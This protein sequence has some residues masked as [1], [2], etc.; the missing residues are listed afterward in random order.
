MIEAAPVREPA[1]ATDTELKVVWSFFS[2][3]MGLDIGLAS[4]G[5][6]ATLALEIDEWACRTIRNNRPELPL[7]EDDIRFW[8]GARL[9][10]DAGYDGDVFLTAGGPPCQSFSPGG[11]RASISDPRGNLIYEYLRLTREVRPRYFIFENVANLV[12][13]AIAHRPISQRPGQH[14]N[15]SKYDTLRPVQ[16]GDLLP[17]RPE[18]LSGSAIRAI[19]ADV[20]NLGYRFAFNVV[21]AADYGAPQHRLR[22]V[23]VGARD[24][25]VPQLPAPTHGPPGSGLLDYVT[26]K[27]AIADLEANPGPSSEYTEQFI[28]Y[29]DLVPPG[30][31]WRSLPPDVAREAM[32]GAYD[33]GGGKTGFFR[34]LAWDRPSPTITG[35]ANRKGAALCH[36]AATRPLSVR[37]AARLQG[38]PDDWD[39]AGSM[40][41]QYR[42]VGDAVPTHLGHAL[43]QVFSTGAPTHA[44][45]PDVEEMLAA[46]ITRLRRSARNRVPR[47]NGN[48]AA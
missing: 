17:L 3:A 28:K 39:I 24:D 29:F 42:Q 6:P 23:M 25:P 34:R 21:D 33:S 5:F 41:I 48:S 2:G 14:W 26:L 18:E 43:G 10:H 1:D 27:D 20:A 45:Q 8:T 4:A 19:L 13:A 31:S 44:G 9:R 7:I 38:F 16:D 32:G 30:G 12:T 35:K 47:T 36:P 46:A 40:G 11:N 15:L 22:F 37:E